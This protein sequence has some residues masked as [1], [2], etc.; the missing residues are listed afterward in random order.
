[1]GTVTLRDAQRE[2]DRRRLEEPREEDSRGLEELREGA[3]ACST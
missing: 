3:A 2:E 1:M